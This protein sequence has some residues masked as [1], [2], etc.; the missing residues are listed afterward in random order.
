MAKPLSDYHE[1]LRTILGDEGDSVA[2]FDF[3]D[4]RLTASLRSV[5][6]LGFV[7]CLSLDDADPSALS[8][9]PVHVDTGAFLVVKAAHLLTAGDHA[10]AI[11]TRAMSI[12]SQPTAVRDRLHVLEYLLEEIESRGNVCATTANSSSL[13]GL[14]AGSTDLMTELK[15][16]VQEH[17]LCCE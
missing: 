7:P 13:P 15:A 16:C 2:G 5:I 3:E 11:R 6:L 17:N 1:A 4:E 12:A 8:S 10:E 14:F 9:A